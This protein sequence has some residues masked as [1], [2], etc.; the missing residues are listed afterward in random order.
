MPDI[1]QQ[2]EW[3]PG[4]PGGEILKQQAAE[5]EET[6][7]AAEQK[8]EAERQAAQEAAAATNLQ[9][10]REAERLTASIM[11]KQQADDRGEAPLG[12][13]ASPTAEIDQKIAK[14]Q[15]QTSTD[16]VMPYLFL[17]TGAATIDILQAVCDFSVVLSFLSS[18]LGMIFS[19][20]RHYTLKY[21]NPN[22]DKKERANMFRRTLISGAI[23][24]IP[25]I[26]ILP[27]QTM[28]MIR[29]WTVRRESI[30]EASHELTK[31]K[32]QRQ[33]MIAQA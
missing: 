6:R 9:Q 25:F 15:K 12:G 10:Q 23:S 13:L 28:F 22:A 3:Q 27:E 30:Q 4:G 24:M 33:K 21:A 18:F 20:T 5:I 16:Y 32:I 2:P 26:D 11:L 31:L 19:V 8:K 1:I 17:T 14:L 7:L 29:E